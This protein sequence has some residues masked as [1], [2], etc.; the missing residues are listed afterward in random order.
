M[1]NKIRGIILSH[2]DINYYKKLLKIKDRK[3]ILDKPEK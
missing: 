2:V 3:E 1:K